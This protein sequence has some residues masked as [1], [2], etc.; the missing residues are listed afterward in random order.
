MACN[1]AHRQAMELAWSSLQ[2]LDARELARASA[3]E[4]REGE[5][6]LQTLGGE[7]LVD[8]RDRMVI[9]PDHVGGCWGLAALHH[10]KGCLS[11]R[12]DETWI[13]FDQVLDARP[14][15]AAFRQRAVA[16]LAL[17]FGAAPKDLVRAARRLGG[18]PLSMG[19]SAVLL[20]AFPRLR[21][22]V[23]VW[24][25]DEEVPGGA[26]LLFDRGGAATLPAEDLAE[27]GISIG[28]A[29]LSTDR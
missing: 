3:G 10:L 16:P 14:F 19:D 26:N 13:S 20:Q 5:L 12:A 28:Q 11:W 15:S 24:R 21:V 8:L 7:T 1:P 23:V 22:A 29:L 17:R 4:L 9:T 18:R 2:G 6:V 27:I 25:G